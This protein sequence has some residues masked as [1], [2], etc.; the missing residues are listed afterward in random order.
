MENVQNSSHVL[1]RLFKDFTRPKYQ[2]CYLKY[3]LQHHDP[4]IYNGERTLHEALK[5]IPTP[6]PFFSKTGFFK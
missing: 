3:I 2:T 6:T 4:K 5:I 1:I